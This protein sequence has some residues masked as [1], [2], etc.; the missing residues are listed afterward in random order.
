[1]NNFTIE[2][3]Q[4]LVG[5]VLAPFA[6]ALAKPGHHETEFIVS[7]DGGRSQFSIYV[8]EDGS[9]HEAGVMYGVGNTSRWMTEG[10]PMSA[11]GDLQGRRWQTFTYNHG[12][13]SAEIRFCLEDRN[14]IIIDYAMSREMLA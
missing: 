11:M 3:R 6:A 1:M 8:E 7:V 9:V 12:P 14:T 10:N 5:V 4:F 2:R 13:H